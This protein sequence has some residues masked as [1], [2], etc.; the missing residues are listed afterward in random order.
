MNIKKNINNTLVPIV[1][2]KEASGMERS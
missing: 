2:E 1:V